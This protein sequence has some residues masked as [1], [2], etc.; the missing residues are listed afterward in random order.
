[1]ILLHVGK[2]NYCGHFY[3]K[4]L[5]VDI[6]QCLPL[7]TKREKCTW[8]ICYDARTGVNAPGTPIMM[9]FFPAQSSRIC[10]KSRWWSE[11][12]PSKFKATCFWRWWIHIE[13]FSMGKSDRDLI[14]SVK[15]N[16]EFSG[17]LSEFWPHHV[18]FLP[19]KQFPSYP[20]LTES[21][22]QANIL[23]GLR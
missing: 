15:V 10:S 14:D 12:A 3:L 17:S 11:T 8:H 13:P 16:S 7:L 21:T 19:L 2:Q 18:Q 4:A 1:M 23:K 9:H 20:A 5:P 6:P 22:I